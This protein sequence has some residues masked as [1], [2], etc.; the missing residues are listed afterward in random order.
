MVPVGNMK[1]PKPIDI[2]SEE[3]L[4]AL[5]QKQ[6]RLSVC[7]AAV[8][9]A[10]LFGLPL[11]NYCFPEIMATRVFGFTLTWLILG[12]GFFPAVWVI[13]YVF[14]QRSMALEEQEVNGV[15]PAAQEPKALP[16]LK[17]VRA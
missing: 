10:G 15:Q 16:A 12:I 4:K 3:F 9:T 5:M 7:C 11:A 8:F 6:F 14:I 17:P 13:A 2:H 1:A